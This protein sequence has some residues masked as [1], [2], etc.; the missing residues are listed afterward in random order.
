MEANNKIYGLIGLARKAGKI[1]FGRE[2]SQETVQKGKAKLVIVA[3][4]SSQRTKESFEKLC[5]K[6]NVPIEIIGE[7]EELS[8]SIGQENKAVIVIKDNNF[9]KELIKR[10]HGGEIIG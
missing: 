5:Q 6:Y 3:K 4:D 2:S 9:A 1:S 7:I 8:K 10:I